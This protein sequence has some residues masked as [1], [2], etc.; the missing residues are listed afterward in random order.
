MLIAAGSAGLLSGKLD[1]HGQFLFDGSFD[2]PLP[3]RAIA[4]VGGLCLVATEGGISVID[5]RDGN[6]LQNL[7][8]IDFPG[9]ARFAVADPDFWAGY[10]PGKGWSLLPS[11]RLVLPGE[12]E[13]LQIVSHT[14][15]RQATPPRYRLNLFNNHGVITVPGILSLPPLA[16][17]RV[18]GAVHGSR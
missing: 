13:T 16:G 17:S 4:V 7:G 12:F 18:A 11:P 9:V 6:S 15:Q 8:E 2:L 3:S 5:I 1:D 14:M 10:V